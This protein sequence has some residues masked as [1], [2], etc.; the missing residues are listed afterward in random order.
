MSYYSFF[1][2]MKAKGYTHLKTYNKYDLWEKN[3]RQITTPIIEYV[4]LK[5]IKEYT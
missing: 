2:L 5:L 1:Q 3:N 4:P